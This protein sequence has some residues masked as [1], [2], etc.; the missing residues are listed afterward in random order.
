MT[1]LYTLTFTSYLTAFI[2]VIVQTIFT[3]QGKYL[4]I[5]NIHQGNYIRNFQ[6]HFYRSDYCCSC[7]I[8]GLHI[9]LCLKYINKCIVNLQKTFNLLVLRIGLLHTI[10]VV[11]CYCCI[12]FNSSKKSVKYHAVANT[13]RLVTEVTHNSH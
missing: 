11:V 7:S 3:Y 2:Y 5:Q 10:T 6:S 12:F 4:R 9:H 1:D 8:L 13:S